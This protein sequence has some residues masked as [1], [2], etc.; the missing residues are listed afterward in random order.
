MNINTL[1]EQL[2]QTEQDA[3]PTQDALKPCPFCGSRNVTDSWTRIDAETQWW[4]G[5][6]NDCGAQTCP[7]SSKATAIAAWNTRPTALA[8]DEL[9]EYGVAAIWY[10]AINAYDHDGIGERDD[11]AAIADL[12]HSIAA[13]RQSPPAPIEPICETCGLATS[14]P[15]ASFCSDGFHLPTL[16]PYT[17][18]QAANVATQAS[19]VSDDMCCRQK[20]L[21]IAAAIRAL[22]SSRKDI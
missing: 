17:L 2:P 21:R 15:N 10:S 4:G 6:C 18:E 14:H 5:Q 8:T 3:T 9:D 19:I 12:K 1:G 16:D 11:D 22:I 7:Y 13:L 20:T